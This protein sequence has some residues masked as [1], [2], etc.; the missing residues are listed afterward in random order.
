MIK[1]GVRLST[2]KHIW[3]NLF[4]N[5]IYY[6][7]VHF[8]IFSAVDFLDICSFARAEK[9]L[10]SW[11]DSLR[12]TQVRFLEKGGDDTT[13]VPDLVFFNFYFFGYFPP[14][15]AFPVIG[16]NLIS[17]FAKG[18]SGVACNSSF[19][20]FFWFSAYNRYFTLSSSWGSFI[21]VDLQHPMRGGSGYLQRPAVW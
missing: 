6:V 2:E 11:K 18:S 16:I 19:C 9:S 17:M 7:V 8:N 20:R 5:H 1:W 14:L 3:E 15:H 12:R 21:S 13:L 10:S 4:W